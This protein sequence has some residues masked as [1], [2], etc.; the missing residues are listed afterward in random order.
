MTG[1]IVC[2]LVTSTIRCLTGRL[3]DELDRAGLRD[4]TIVVLWGDHGYQLGEH[5]LWNKHTN[6]EIATRSPLIISA[7][8]ETKQGAH[9]DALVELVDVYPTLVELAGLPMQQGLEGTSVVPLLN[10]PNL[11]WKRAAFSQYP[12]GRVMGYSIRTDRY[13]YTEWS[14][15]GKAPVGVELYDH[16]TD[17]GENINVADLPANDSVVVELSR[18]LKSGWR[19]AKPS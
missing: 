6:F 17:E 12:R 10:R 16:R 14:E 7:P 9:T 13:R 19:A 8:G 18:Q 1:M 3:I 4:N 5:G 15:R 2:P 11:N